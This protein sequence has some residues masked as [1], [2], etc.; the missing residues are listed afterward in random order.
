MVADLLR[1]AAEFVRHSFDSILRIENSFYLVFRGGV[2]PAAPA[3]P[4]AFFGSGHTLGSD[5][6]E[7]TFIPDPTAGDGEQGA[8]A[9]ELCCRYR[10]KD[11]QRL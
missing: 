7:S 5:E 4:T 6:V 1:R 10:L 8:F 3:R 2:A 9:F 11:R